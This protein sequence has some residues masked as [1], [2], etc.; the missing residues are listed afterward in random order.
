MEIS[1]EYSQ[2]LK[3]Y[4][5][6][7]QNE[8]PTEKIIDET[9][10][11]LKSSTSDDDEKMTETISK[12][13]LNDVPATDI[14]GSFFSDFQKNYF[15]NGNNEKQNDKAK[16]E[17][18]EK[19]L[20]KIGAQIFELFF[21]DKNG[22]E[23]DK[24][25]ADQKS[26]KYIKNL[27]SKLESKKLRE[28]L[29]G[30]VN[31]SFEN[32]EENKKVILLLEKNGLEYFKDMLSKYSCKNL[33]IDRKYLEK[34]L[35]KLFKLTK[36]L[37]YREEQENKKNSKIETEMEI[38]EYFNIINE[39]IKQNVIKISDEL[40]HNPFGEIKTNKNNLMDN[41]II[42]NESKTSNKA[43][44]TE[45]HEEEISKE[46]RESNLFIVLMKILVSTFFEELNKLDG[47]YKYENLPK[48]ETYFTDKTQKSN[49]L[50]SD[51][52]SIVG[53]TKKTLKV[54]ANQKLDNQKKVNNL[55]KMKKIDYFKEIIKAKGKEL[56]K[57]DIEKEEKSYQKLKCKN[58][59]YQ[60]FR[61]KNIEGLILVLNF[62]SFDKDI[63]FTIKEKKLEE[64]EKAINKFEGS[65]NFSIK[66]TENENG[67]IKKRKEKL[68]KI[69]ENPIDFG[70]NII[71][72]EK[73]SNEVI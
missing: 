53:K 27:M 23:N 70:D 37:Q 10:D 13:L 57:G 9:K 18:K 73:K 8:D 69:V 48:I 58:K 3:L 11:F 5:V 24:E 66:L 43:Y 31:I 2:N 52:S 12:Y 72:K 44:E 4:K 17:V 1:L 64:F 32:N 50:N 30:I 61:L 65:K 63:Y 25:T 42:V 22:C 6:L 28:L 40:N 59:V 45:I 7:F 26:D 38:E 14:N 19:L 33:V 56:I 54:K 60:Y 62:V 55:I 46:D 51:F 68:E 39:N 20:D 67:N 36:A 41:Q 29:E 16:M 21:L 34:K 49:F 35:Q 47:I 15:I 71:P